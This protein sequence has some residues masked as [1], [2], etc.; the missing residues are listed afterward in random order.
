V[1]DE[2]DGRVALTA[3]FGGGR[4]NKDKAKRFERDASL[5]LTAPKRSATAAAAAAAIAAP[6]A[7]ARRSGDDEETDDE[8][9]LTEEV[10]VRYKYDMSN[11]VLLFMCSVGGF[12]RVSF[13]G[14]V[15]GSLRVRFC[16]CPLPPLSHREKQ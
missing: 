12:V 3:Q 16:S 5:L 1:F 4:K 11:S 14:S 2:S 10:F 9:Q 8:D 6:Q 13:R 15:R 7:T